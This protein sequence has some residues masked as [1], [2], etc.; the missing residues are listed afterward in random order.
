MAV[1]DS[2]LFTVRDPGASND[3]T[4]EM[5][6]PEVRDDAVVVNT[7]VTASERTGLGPGAELRFLAQLPDGTF[8]TRFITAVFPAADFTEQV[9]F[10]RDLDRGT[11]TIG[12]TAA[13]FDSEVPREVPSEQ[14]LSVSVDPEEAPEPTEP[15]QTRI[16]QLFLDFDA[17]TLGPT[18]STTTDVSAQ[19]SSGKVT[20]TVADVNYSSDDTSVATVS[21]VGTVFAEGTGTADITATVSTV[22]GP[23]SDTEPVT[24]E[25]SEQPVT[26]PGQPSDAARVRFPFSIFNAIPG[27]EEAED[28]VVTIPQRADIRQL[29][30]DVVPSQQDIAEAVTAEITFPEFPDVPSE[31]DIRGELLAG[32]PFATVPTVSQLRDETQAAVDSIDIPEPPAVEDITDPV[33]STIDALQEDLEGFID[34]TEA[35]LDESISAT[36][37]AIDNTLS[38]IDSAVSDAQDSIDT[39]VADIDSGFSDVQ[40]AIDELPDSVPSLEDIVADTTAAVITEIEAQIIPTQEG[41]LL[42]D[43]PPRFFAIAIENFLQEALSTDTL[44]RAQERAQEAE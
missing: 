1:G 34:D 9:E 32:E 30:N 36:E 40:D 18:G 23:V 39:A 11:F 8:E 3:I 28:F 24:V 12:V 16:E 22:D 27:I 4:V 2:L 33:D 35:S 26:V 38:D 21:S 6:E 29:L 10:T 15:V 37:T 44:Q 20:D 43:D 13:V 14:T 25:R 7:Q 19:L 42:T 41:V 17:D 31:S 5:R